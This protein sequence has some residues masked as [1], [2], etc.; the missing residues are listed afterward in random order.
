MFSG[1][2][3]GLATLFNVTFDCIVAGKVEEKVALENEVKLKITSCLV[4]IYA[5]V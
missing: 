4:K 2:Q 1:R 3:L 5:H